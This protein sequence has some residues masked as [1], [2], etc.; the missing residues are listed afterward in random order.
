MP[1]SLTAF[2]ATLDRATGTVVKK[3]PRV[4]QRGASAEVRVAVR[5]AGTGMAGPN[6]RMQPVPME[7][8]AI[9]KDMGRLLLRRNGETVAAGK[10][11]IYIFH[12]LR[13]Y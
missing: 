6:A 2:A 12:A 13:S 5:A 11:A 10:P 1:A 7:P 9:N 4:L 3:S 8:F